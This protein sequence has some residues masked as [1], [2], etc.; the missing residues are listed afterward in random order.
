MKFE[1]IPGLAATKTLLI[2]GLRN[3]HTAHAQLFAGKPGSLVLPLALAYATYLHCENKGDDACGTCAACSKSLKYI[4][5]DTHFV[6][7]VGN[8]KRSGEIKGSG[9]EETLKAELRKLWRSFLMEQPFGI[10]DDWAAFY[11]G[12]DKQA[13]ISTEESREMLKT[14][15]LKPFESKYKIV[16]IWQPEFMHIAAANSILKILEEPPPNTYFILATHASDKLLPTILSRTQ[17]V[18]VPMLTDEEVTSYLTNRSTDNK[19]SRRVAQLAEGNLHLALRL[20]DNE[21]DQH[22]KIFTDWMRSCFQK[23]YANLVA[24]AEEYHQLDRLNQ[25]NLL[26]Y[27]LGMLRETL[28]E[29]SGS[30]DLHRVQEEELELI[31]K[32]SKVMDL[33]K[34]EKS[35]KLLNDASYHLERN[36]SAKMIFLDLSLQLS[37]II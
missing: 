16:I 10:L 25:R 37:R 20:L 19:R 31:R 9:D 33:K 34:I 15:S 6:F 23:N 4:H 32:F 12:E 5:P 29:I 2:T 36:G 24:M 30:P 11:G 14:L 1:S 21:E 18:T 7:P 35:V 22:T 28:L 3:G 27:S 8:M 26:Q 13:I 17:M